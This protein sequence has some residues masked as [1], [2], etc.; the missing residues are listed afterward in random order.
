M[1]Q[2]QDASGIGQKG[3][4]DNGRRAALMILKSHDNPNRI[5]FRMHDKPREVRHHVNDTASMCANW[6]KQQE[7]KPAHNSRML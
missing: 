5:P 1:Q 6:Q 3:P 7:F 2:A 4:S